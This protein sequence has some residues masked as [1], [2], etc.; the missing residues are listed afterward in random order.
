MPLRDDEFD[1]MARIVENRKDERVA[2][3]EH[4]LVD[5]RVSELARG[6]QVAFDIVKFVALLPDAR[7]PGA[8]SGEAETDLRSCRSSIRSRISIYMIRPVQ[9]GS[10]CVGRCFIWGY[11]MAEAVLGVAA[12]IVRVGH[13]A[14]RAGTRQV[15]DE[16]FGSG[17]LKELVEVLH[18]TLKG[19]GVGLAA[20]QIAVPLRL[21]V[22]ED[23]EERMRHLSSEQ[24]K[25]IGRE[26]FPFEAV[27]NPTC[28][29]C[30]PGWRSRRK[31][32]SV[33]PT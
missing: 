15:R 31:D 25:K 4:V 12:E 20:P 32:V 27:V 33:F 19:K 7:V 28:A 17:A 22:A 16:L 14:L 1:G 26:P 30:P 21:F 29:L 23:T 10:A 6:L 2:F 11:R 5:Q 8:V 24:R 13:P 18:A 9:A 3:G